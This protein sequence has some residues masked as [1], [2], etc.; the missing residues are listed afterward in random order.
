MNGGS[1]ESQCTQIG[2]KMPEMCFQEPELIKR[3]CENANTGRKIPVIVWRFTHFLLP[4][5]AEKN[6]SIG[7]KCQ[8]DG[9]VTVALQWYIYI[10]YIS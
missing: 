3:S 10:C 7:R 1:F 6:D 4:I 2:E 8:K 5:L 9:R